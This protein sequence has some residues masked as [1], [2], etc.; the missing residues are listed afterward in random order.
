VAVKALYVGLG[1]V[2]GFVI[3][4]ATLVSRAEDLDRA[5]SQDTI[6]AAN[7]AGVRLV[8]LLGAVSTTGVP[9]RAYLISVGEL[10][11]PATVAQAGVAPPSPLGATSVS[12]SVDRLVDCL[13]WHESRGFAGAYNRGS[14]ASGLLQFLPSTFATTPQGKAGLSPFDPSAARAAAKWM[15]SQGR[16]HEWSTWRMCA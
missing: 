9:G 2:A 4:T 15:I 12:S 13:A 1:M 6:A 11:S 5:V 16:L 10:A 8:D 7:E 3:G 14:G